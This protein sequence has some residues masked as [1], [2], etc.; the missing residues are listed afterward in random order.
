M[1]ISC[2]FIIHVL[3]DCLAYVNQL[4]LVENTYFLS[5]GLVIIHQIFTGIH[6]QIIIIY[7]NIYRR[8]AVMLSGPICSKLTASFFNVL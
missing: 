7:K 1:E 3:L 6:K 4:A 5:V 2:L 8:F